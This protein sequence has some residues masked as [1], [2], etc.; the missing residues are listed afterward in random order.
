MKKLC[1]IACLSLVGCGDSLTPDQRKAVAV[2]REFAPEKSESELSEVVRKWSADDYA[3][4]YRMKQVKDQRPDVYFDAKARADR[5][6][7]SAKVK[8]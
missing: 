5:A 3:R 7:E 4:L 1:L 6:I 8:P 2:M